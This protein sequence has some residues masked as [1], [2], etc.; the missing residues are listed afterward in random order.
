[1]SNWHFSPPKTGQQLPSSI[2]PSNS[3][4]LPCGS[5]GV[6]ELMGLQSSRHPWTPYYATW[7]KISGLCNSGD[8]RLRPL[9]PK[10][11]STWAQTKGLPVAGMWDIPHLTPKER[12]AKLQ[13]TGPWRIDPASNSIPFC[14]KK[15]LCIFPLKNL[16]WHWSFQRQSCQHRWKNKQVGHQS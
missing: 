5:R 1:M 16:S 9:A 13:L 6:K 14:G 3:R 2:S 8:W 11:P 7:Y 12:Y 15:N 10:G 4:E